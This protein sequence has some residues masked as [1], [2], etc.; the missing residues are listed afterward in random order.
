LNRRDLLILGSTAIALP[1]AARAQQMAMPVIG[2]LSARSPGESAP[3]MAAFHQG[4]SETGYVEGKNLVIEYRWAEGQNDRLPALAADLVARK[5]EVIATTGGPA[6]AVAAKNATSTIPIVFISGT[7][8]V[9]TGLVA[10]LA[11]RQ[12]Y[13]CKHSAHRTGRQA[14]RISIRTGS[15]CQGD[16]PSREPEQSGSRTYDPRG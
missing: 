1:L 14:A 7:D 2:F 10:S 5:V 16:G 9:A 12:S 13:G 11:R 6:P 8:P 3:L 15:R 4:L